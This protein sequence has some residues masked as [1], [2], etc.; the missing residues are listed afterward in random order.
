M[1]N[2]N[3]QPRVHYKWPGTVHAGKILVALGTAST[4]LSARAS[5]R[6]VATVRSKAFRAVLCER[7]AMA[8]IGYAFCMA[9]RVAFAKRSPTGGSVLWTVRRPPPP[10][11]P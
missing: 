6:I 11:R 4:G 8:G 1:R 10:K 5:W 7:F 2:P 9:I 3:R